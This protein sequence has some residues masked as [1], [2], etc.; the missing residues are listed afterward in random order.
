MDWILIAV[1]AGNV[2]TGG[3]STREACEGRVFTLGDQHK[4]EA[5]CVQAPGAS[6]AVSFGSSSVLQTCALVN[7]SNLCMGGRQ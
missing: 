3:F 1:V 2:V 4:I 7:G 5:K 6:G